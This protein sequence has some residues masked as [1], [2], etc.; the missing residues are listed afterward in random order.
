MFTTETIVLW[1]EKIEKIFVKIDFTITTVSHLP[2]SVTSIDEGSV[3]EC[4][5]LVKR[6]M[7]L[8]EDLLIEAFSLEKEALRCTSP[9]CY[10]I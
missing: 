5:L 7:S 2:G 6:L 1:R 9:D 10:A 8:A 3:A 4:L